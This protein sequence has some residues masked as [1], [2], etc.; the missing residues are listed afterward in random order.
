MD[1][2]TVVVSIRLPQE[3][4]DGYARKA[5]EYGL[6]RSKMLGLALRLGWFVIDDSTGHQPDEDFQEDLFDAC[7][8]VIAHGEKQR[9]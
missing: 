4:A 5:K 3:I 8:E 2:K 6:P 9:H 1:K 7:A